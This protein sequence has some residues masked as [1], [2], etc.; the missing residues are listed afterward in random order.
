MD[1]LVAPEQFA[2]P[3]G[4]VA[5]AGP[6]VV[7]AALAEGVQ[8]G[9]DG[10]RILREFRRGKEQ[11]GFGAG[12]ARLERQQIE[13]PGVVD[14]VNQ[15]GQLFPVEPL[16]ERHHVH[17]HFFERFGV[18]PAQGG[19]GAGQERF[20]QGGRERVF[21][22]QQPADGDGGVEGLAGRGG[23]ARK[24][25][26]VGQFA[27]AEQLMGG[28]G[29]GGFEEIQ[30]AGAVFE[31]DDRNCNYVGIPENISVIEKLLD[32]G[33]GANRLVLSGLRAGALEDGEINGAEIDG[34]EPA[35]QQQQNRSG[36]ADREP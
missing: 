19:G 35:A 18:A 16:S 31:A 5:Q 3:A 9:G 15:D 13:R 1:A 14:A 25:D 32:A 12:V 28:G 27:A 33:R 10:A 36:N 4:A 29:R 34:D 7:Q 8:V 23:G 30:D 2:Q 11:G 6:Q 21:F 17:E 26:G 20:T 22:Q 24:Q